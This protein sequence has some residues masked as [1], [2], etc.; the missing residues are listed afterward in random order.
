MVNH[1][2]LYEIAATAKNFEAFKAKYGKDVSDEQLKSIFDR[3]NKQQSRLTIKDIFKYASLKDLTSALETKSGKEV[4]KSIKTSEANILVNNEKMMIVEP[5]TMAASLKYGA[6]TKWCTTYSDPE[7]N[8]F[9]N[10][11]GD[12]TLVYFI[13]KIH[14]TKYAIAYN[15]NNQK[16]TE[17]FDEKDEFIKS[18]KILK[19]FNVSLEEISSKT[20]SSEEKNKVLQ[21]NLTK[22]I[23][24]RIVGDVIKG[25]VDI[26]NKNLKKITDILDFSKIEVTGNFLCYDNQLTTLEGA[27]RRVG[28][29]FYCNNNQLTSLEGAP[30]EIGFFTTNSR[31]GTFNCSNNKLTSL[32][33]APQKVGGGF[34][35]DNNQ[36]TSLAGAPREVGGHFYCSVNQLTSLTGAPKEVG[37]HF[38]SDFSAEDVK[39]AMKGEVSEILIQKENNMDKIPAYYSFYTDLITEGH[40]IMADVP[41][42]ES[43][44]EF[45]KK[46]PNECVY[47]EVGENY[48]KEANPHVTVMYGLS[49]IEETRV[50][51]LLNKVPKKIVAELGK[52][53]KFSNADTPY[54]VLKIEVKSPHLNKIHEMIR[55]NFDNNYKWSEYN[56]HVTLAYVKK[57]TC[58]EY[59]GNKTFEGMKVM[60]ETFMYSNGIRELNH[61]V[62]MKEYYVGQS[63]GYGGGAMAGGAVAATNWAGTFSSNQTSRRLQNYPA[64]R[65]YTYMQGNTVIGSPLYDTLTDDDLIDPNF[66]KDE[67]RTGLR[68]E[69]KRM[70]YPDKD[71]A[72]PTV[73]KNL[74]KNPKYYSDLEMYFQSDK[75]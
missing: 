4:E 12:Y 32:K 30:Q 3:F 70:E 64:Q 60:F 47:E 20:I 15:K 24:S 43:M 75:I 65:K 56:P 55:K 59:V 11:F 29:G 61:A 41:Q 46:I 73:L 17:S 18:S 34:Y 13:D 48:G 25:H 42:K 45:I 52:I 14:N 23:E 28:M 53:S 7:E 57:G 58:N 38:K 36:L 33:G 6:N 8:R 5:L 10:Y 67:I 49:P 68:Y 54:D 26:M 39:K 16:D 50:K 66:T 72:K 27:P 1:I 22:D 2:K 19:I 51:E 44:L 74:H 31:G 62:P 37:G 21:K 35:C 63:A 71:V 40:C 69:M 9:N